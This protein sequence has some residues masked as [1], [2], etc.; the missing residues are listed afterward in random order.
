MVRIEDPNDVTEYPFV[1]KD[2]GPVE[3]DEY[4]KY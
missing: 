3:L 1:W 4:F 2:D